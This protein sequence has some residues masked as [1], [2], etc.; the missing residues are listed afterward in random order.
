M[1]ERSGV[2]ITN[3]L[4]FVLVLV[5]AGAVLRLTASIFI[6]LVVAILLSFVLNP[7]VGY[8]RRLGL[9]KGIAVMTVLVLLMG[10]SGLVGLLF[11][12]SVQS[13]ARQF[14]VY[15]ARLSQLLNDFIELTNLPA[16]IVEEFNIAGNL[17]S[18]I[19]SI[20]G[21]IA[22][23]LGSLMMV[24]VFVLFILLEQPYM[25]AKLMSALNGP[26]TERVARIVSGIS[27]QIGRYLSVKL[28]VSAMTALI[29]YISFSIIG[30]DF[31]FIW[32]ILTFLFNFI[33]SIGSI[34]ITAL[35]S[36]FALLQ[37]V[38]DWNLVFAAFASMAVTQLLIG[39]VL[40][41]KLQGDSLNLS[42]VI[43]LFSLLLWGWIWG[44]IGMFLAVPLTVG[45]KIVFE[46]VPGMEWI[47]ILMGTGNYR[48][49][50]RRIQLRNQ[51]RKV[52]GGGLRESVGS[53]LE[54]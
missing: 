34:A 20:S 52:D 23:F 39:N 2:N 5:A 4:L 48:E 11:Y 26:R 44:V 37:F 31:A 32:A 30:V 28:V 18:M 45:I 25:H 46:N 3:S 15:Q 1:Q 24:I 12:T 27:L 33:P 54:G 50:A 22:G 29:V 16:N 47:G 51:S 9:P 14:P 49:R 8:L 7:V 42:P 53:D 38:P 35:S 17:S 10:F 19:F 36:V 21:N 40:D 13:L 41:P 43:I 6:P